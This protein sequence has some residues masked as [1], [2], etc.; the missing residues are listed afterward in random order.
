MA[1]TFG[2]MLS[3]LC[4]EVDPREGGLLKPEVVLRG[5]LQSSDW[6]VICTVGHTNG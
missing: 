2:G 5:S 4:T 6:C 3:E 1:A